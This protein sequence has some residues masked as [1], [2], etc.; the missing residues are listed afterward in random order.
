[1]KNFPTIFFLL[2]LMGFQTHAAKSY[3]MEVRNLVQVNESE[4]TFE[5]RMRNTSN[6]IEPFAIEA[7]QWQFSFNPAMLN[8]GG[9]R[10]SFLTYIDNT[11]DLVGTRIIPLSTNFTTNQVVIQWVTDPLG[12][13]EQTTL[14]D[15]NSWKRIGTFS[16]KLSTAANGTTRHNFADVAHNLNFIAN[17]VYVSECPYYWDS[18]NSWW[19][20][21]NANF[22]EITSRV[23][24]NSIDPNRELAGYYM[25]ANTDWGTAANW[26]NTVAAAHPAYHKLPGVT[27]NALVGVASVISTSTRASIKNLYFNVGGSLTIKSDATGTGYLI[28]NNSGVAATI[29]RYLSQTKYH[30]VSSP[31][32]NAPYTVLQGVNGTDDFF[33]WNE[34]VREWTNLNFVPL[35]VGT[36]T[37]GKGYAVAYGGVLPVTK[38]FVGEINVGTVGFSA[39]YTPGSVSPFWNQRGF[40]LVG[41]PY[42]CALDANAFLTAHSSVYG[43]YFWDE[44]ANYL[45]NRNDYATYSLA[46]G[47]GTAPGVGGANTNAPTGKIAPMQG[48]M[49]QVKSLPFNQN[50]TIPINFVNTM[51]ITDDAYFY[52]DQS[53]NDRIWLSVKGPEQDYNEILVAFM[54]GAQVDLDQSDAEKLKGNSMLAFYSMLEGGDFVIQG[55]PVLNSTDTYE[56]PLGVDAG[57]AGQYTFDVQ[58]IEN[59]VSGTA[60]TLEDR[61]AGKM[62]NLRTNP[63]YVAQISTPGEIRGRF[64]LHFNGPTSVPVIEQKLTKVYAINNQIFVELVGNNKILD[65]EVLN[66]LGQSVLRTSVN[67]TEATINVNGSNVVYI[68]KVRTSQ[69]VESHKILLH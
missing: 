52:K 64:Y 5:V 43:L 38:Q 23:L 68:V 2:L 61:L 30:Y 11:T 3:E 63:Q 53:E 12:L 40:N 29:E 55:L 44:A 15:D 6:P 42:S 25:Y 66:T 7:M 24:T 17:M 27:N 37:P 56:I 31:I 9:L 14:F 45:G 47:V 62:I 49:L 4:F 16:L 48:F 59:F 26:N 13:D 19:V 32:S 41:N 8:G 50:A 33:S 57:L 34:S 20:R 21:D 65:V 51:R 60:I 22:S 67:A 58:K 36:L 1:M 10:N 39:T 69:G 46:G 54:D 28:H 35:P 18:E